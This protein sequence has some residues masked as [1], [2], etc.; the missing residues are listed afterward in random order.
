MK[1]VNLLMTDFNKEVEM[2]IVFVCQDCDDAYRLVDM[3]FKT[4]TGI[5]LIDGQC[6]RC[7][8]KQMED[9]KKLWIE[10][11]HPVEQWEKQVLEQHT[12]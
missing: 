2:K 6:Q 10:A 12:I 3:D 11:G 9:L 1:R 4:L 8:E 5:H 7:F